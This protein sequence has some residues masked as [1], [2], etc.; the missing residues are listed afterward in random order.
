M[1]LVVHTGDA[2]FDS[3]WAPADDVLI[4][5]ATRPLVEE[6]YEGW[7]PVELS[8]SLDEAGARTVSLLPGH[9]LDKP[10][11][12]LIS[13]DDLSAYIQWTPL[14]TLTF[15]SASALLPTALSFPTLH[16]AND[17]L[18]PL[19]PPFSAQG[20][21]ALPQ[22]LAPSSTLAF[23]L[24]LVRHLGHFTLR[25]GQAIDTPS[26]LFVAV[27]STLFG[28]A[29][30]L[31]VIGVFWMAFGKGLWKEAMRVRGGGMAAARERGKEIKIAAPGMDEEKGG[32]TLS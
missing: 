27:A 8:S 4:W 17:P 19:E 6:E 13:D 10:P 5:V 31:G 29:F 7:V 30:K 26:E 11:D 24:A 25:L 1:A 14:L 3:W 9:V 18:Q 21:P 28:W 32:T 2:Y 15:P 12:A 23:R 22:V 20:R 16:I